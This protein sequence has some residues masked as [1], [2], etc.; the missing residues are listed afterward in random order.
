MLSFAIVVPNLNQ[1]HFLPD[2]LEGLR[3]QT[4]PFELAIMDG[5]S[6]DGFDKVVN[7]YSDIIT[8]LRSGQDKGQAAAIKEGKDKVHGDVLAWLNADD[9]YFPGT[10]NK[11]ATCFEQ[12][13]ELDV[14]YGDAIHVSPEGFFLSYFP[15][16]Q[17]FSAND[18]TSNCFICQPAC[19][20]RRVAYEK[21]GGIDPTLQYTMDWD[22]WCRLSDSGA[23]F[24]YLHEVLAAV[25]YYHGTKTLSRN[26][27]RY[28]E[29]WRI[30][31]KYGHRFFPRSWLGFYLFDLSFT[32]KKN[33]VE[34]YFFVLLNYLRRLKNRLV[35]KKDLRKDSIKKNYG[36]HS[37]EP[38]VE[39][40]GR[41]HMPW[42]GTKEWTRLILKVD[43]PN[44]RYRFKINGRECEK[45]LYKN[46][47]LIVDLPK[48]EN[49]HREISIECM[50]S[51]KW[52][53]LEFHFD[54]E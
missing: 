10:L 32:N 34:K 15:A 35:N 41:I 31:R 48:L 38:L 23:K 36:F 43:P 5:G 1:S 11:V 24:C 51:K 45:V 49:P 16:I 29:I 46:G 42:Y 7:R 6:A 2:A 53:L 47:H 26:W 14:V 19:F 17:E 30:E 33:L 20:V 28:M 44:D 9:Y 3:Y 27:K 21:V 12:H 13:P 37:W 39:G 22:L 8:Y 40:K 18:L 52:Q 4:S 54:L 50:E 25:R